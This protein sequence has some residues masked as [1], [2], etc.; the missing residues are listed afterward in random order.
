MIIGIDGLGGAGKT[1]KAKE[2]QDILNKYGISSEILHIDDF[3]HPRN[4]R[5]VDSIEEWKCYYDLQWRYD[6]ISSILK[7]FK[8]EETFFE[9]I[10]IYN[11]EADCYDIKILEL[12]PETVLIIEGVFLQKKNLKTFSILLCI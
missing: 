8:K 12:K 2:L 9:E 1:S 4:I 3:I 11:K 6:Y 7:K 10:E 5:Y